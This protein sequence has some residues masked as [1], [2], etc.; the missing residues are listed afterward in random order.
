[1]TIPHL[2]NRKGTKLQ[3]MANKRSHHLQNHHE[4]DLA[5]GKV[6]EA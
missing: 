3:A 5:E 1:M 4:A 6:R 2:D